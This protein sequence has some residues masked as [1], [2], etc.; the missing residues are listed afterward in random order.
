MI[1]EVEGGQEEA[2]LQKAK[3]GT[4]KAEEKA[5]SVKGSRELQTDKRGCGNLL[6]AVVT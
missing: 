6:S 5:N 4:L 2:T 1:E 3:E